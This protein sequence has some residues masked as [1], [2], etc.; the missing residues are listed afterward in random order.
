[1]Q[2][3]INSKLVLGT[4]ADRVKNVELAGIAWAE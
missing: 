1:M 4:K 3:R 2:E